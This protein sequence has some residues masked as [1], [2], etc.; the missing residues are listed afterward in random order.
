MN[1]KELS[2][3][4]YLDK[5]LKLLEKQLEDIKRNPMFQSNKK[6]KEEIISEIVKKQNDC[7][8]ERVRLEKYINS[9]T[10]SKIRYIAKLRFVEF[11]NWYDIAD[12]ITP[13]DK[14]LVDRTTPFYALKSYLSKN[15]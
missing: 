9:I 4:Y 10:D 3:Y 13:Y 2:N 8:N 7:I 1:I 11:K 5:E 6:M 15:K 14:E 12:I